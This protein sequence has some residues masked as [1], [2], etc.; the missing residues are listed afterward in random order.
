[1]SQDVSELLTEELQAIVGQ[2]GQ[3]N[4]DSAPAAAVDEMEPITKRSSPF[5]AAPGIVD[6]QDI[7][8]S[9]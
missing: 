9:E 4:S 2:E 1:M 8:A 5:E 7:F 3:T 6:S